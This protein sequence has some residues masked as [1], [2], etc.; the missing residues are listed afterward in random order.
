M[1]EKNGIKL[2]GKRELRTHTPQNEYKERKKREKVT[3][4]A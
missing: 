4:N 3:V 2:G 1:G